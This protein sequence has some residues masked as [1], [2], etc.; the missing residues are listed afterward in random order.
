MNTQTW[1]AELE[2]IFVNQRPVVCSVAAKVLGSADQADDVVQDAYLKISE[3]TT[4][5]DLQTPCR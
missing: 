2:D 3:A 1:S 4:V 5:F